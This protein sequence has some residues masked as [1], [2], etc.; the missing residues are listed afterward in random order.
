MDHIAQKEKPLTLTSNVRC[1]LY[2]PYIASRSHN[3]HYFKITVIL[4]S[5][6]DGKQE[7]QAE[8]YGVPRWTIIANPLH[9][10]LISKI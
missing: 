8:L 9:F 6:A 2:V 5:A 3:K 7:E 4:D 1:P 10:L